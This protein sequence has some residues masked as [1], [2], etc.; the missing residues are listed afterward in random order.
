MHYDPRTGQAKT[1]EELAF[2][3]DTQFPP[4]RFT[5]IGFHH[6]WE[7]SPDGVTELIW[8]RD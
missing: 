3:A 4:Q 6:L 7:V 2:Y 5:F 8:H 1:L